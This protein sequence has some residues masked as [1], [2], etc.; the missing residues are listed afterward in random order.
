LPPAAS[1]LL[2]A[3]FTLLWAV[4]PSAVNARLRWP[5]FRSTLRS[6]TTARAVS[7]KNGSISTAKHSGSRDTPRWR[8]V[9]RGRCL[10]ADF[11]SHAV[12]PL[13]ETRFSS[14]EARLMRA[15]PE[16]PQVIRPQRSLPQAQLALTRHCRSPAA[17]VDSVV[18]GRL[19][20]AGVGR[21]GWPRAEG[22]TAAHGR[23]S[24]GRDV[25]SGRVACRVPGDPHSVVAVTEQSPM[26][27]R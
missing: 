8:R 27:G 7:A 16:H 19:R 23:G 17:E 4:Q 21:A 2:G 10:L 22:T 24:A 12:T 11:G 15:H 18:A 20:P 1:T 5:V 3:G 25:E 26:E 6:R 14:T 9:R 13:R